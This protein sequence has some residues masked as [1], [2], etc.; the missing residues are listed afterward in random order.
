MCFRQKNGIQI[1][2]MLLRRNQVCKMALF[3]VH[4]R[5]TVG[6]ITLEIYITGIFVNCSHRLLPAWQ[7]CYVLHTNKARLCMTSL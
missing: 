5:F 7:L 2:Y 4:Y 3:P 6:M 1:M